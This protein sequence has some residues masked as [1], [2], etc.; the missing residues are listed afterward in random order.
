IIEDYQKNIEELN[1]TIDQK[2]EELKR[3][4]D[5][6]CDFIR[7]IEQ[8]ED[9]IEEL[10]MALERRDMEVNILSLSKD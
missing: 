10:T 1:K 5:T 4:E 2:S 3:T 6:L 7:N 8:Q 9:R